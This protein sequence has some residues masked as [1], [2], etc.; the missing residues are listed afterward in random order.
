MKSAIETL[1]KVG[2]DQTSGK[3]GADN[4]QFRAGKKVLLQTMQT[5]VGHALRA[6]SALLDPEQQSAATA[7]L[8]GPFTGTYTS[9]SAVVMGILKNM[10]DTF[11]KNLGD[12]IRTEK[13]AVEAY[14]E[15]MKLKRE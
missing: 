7:F 4:S 6:A 15:F 13:D 8:Q 3:A 14:D 5:E 9:Q 2:A 12:A 1:N 10:R 11:E